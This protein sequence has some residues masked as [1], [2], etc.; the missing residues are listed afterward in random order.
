MPARAIRRVDP[1]GDDAF[2]ILR[3]DRV[4]DRLAVPVDV[5]NQLDA[6][7]RLDVGRSAH[8]NNLRVRNS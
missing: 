6:A 2:V 5:L 7:A 3:C 8:A 4:E 1:L